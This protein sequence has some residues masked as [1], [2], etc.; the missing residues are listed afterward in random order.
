MNTKTLALRILVAT[1]LILL[2]ACSGP[3]LSYE[4]SGPGI[5]PDWQ[6]WT[7]E[8]ITAYGVNTGDGRVI[9]ND[10]AYAS[11]HAVVT[12]DGRPGLPAELRPGQV[13]LVRGRID[14]GG[15]TGTADRIDCDAR[16]VG[17]VESL[18]SAGHRIGV[19]GQVV[20][21]GPGTVFAAGIDPASYAGLSIGSNVELSGFAR[22]DGAILATRIDQA[23]ASARLQLVGDVAELD[24][25][26]FRFT[27]GS[28]A[29]DYSQA[30]VIDLPGGAPRNGAAINATG[31]MSSGRFVVETLTAAPALPVATG[32][33]VQA[34]GVVT[35]FV[36]AGDFDVNDVAV[37]TTATT[38]FR[39]GSR[40]DLALNTELVVDGYA[41]S[42][43]RITADRVSF[44]R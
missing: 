40:N 39:D 7:D 19:M 32:R 28:L 30:L 38:A 2:A 18:D 8:A 22:A 36:S 15:L 35:R 14:D 31:R 10:V 5:T 16:L 34:A 13:V 42:T 26:T 27:V 6:P 21:T 1:L 3:N 44:G 24:L 25:A 11:Q 29:V 41:A 43:G 9:L 12:I 33:R 20:I 17:P 37:T 23:A 4:I